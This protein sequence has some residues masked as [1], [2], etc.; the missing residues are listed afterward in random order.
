M[1]DSRD[2]KIKEERCFQEILDVTRFCFKKK[3]V[4]SFSAFSL[5]L[6][7]LP[8]PNYSLLLLTQRNKPYEDSYLL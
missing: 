1:R 5:N 8:G 6:R 3:D 2:D 7:S 4:T